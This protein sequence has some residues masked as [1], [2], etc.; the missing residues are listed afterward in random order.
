MVEEIKTFEERKKALIKKG[1]ADGFITYEEL[2]SELKG[3]DLDSD[4]LDELYNSLIENNI[5]IVSDDD[6]I[7]NDDNDDDDG[8]LE[9]QSAVFEINV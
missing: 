6:Y 4:A 5:E 8:N 1:K 9:K 7:G 3:L 2:A